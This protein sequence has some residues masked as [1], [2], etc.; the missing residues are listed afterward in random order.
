MRNRILNIAATLLIIIGAWSTIE[1]LWALFLPEGFLNLT[2]QMTGMTI[3]QTDLIRLMTQ[4]YGM[5]ALVA[6][7]LYCVISFIPYRRAEKW[8]WYAM[9]FIGGISMIAMSVLW[10]PHAP[11][12]VIFV[13]LWIIGLALPAKQILSKPSK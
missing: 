3:T 9:L 12:S 5:K 8:A 11:F 7:L 1:G 6:G 13:I 10:V 4:F 2:G